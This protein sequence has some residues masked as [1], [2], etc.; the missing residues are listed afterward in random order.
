MATRFNNESTGACTGEV[1]ESRAE[2]GADRGVNRKRRVRM[3]I[4]ATLVVAITGPSTGCTM[5]SGMHRALTR[6]DGLDEFMVNYRNNAW[7]ARAWLCTK[8]EYHGHRYL[9][10]LEAGFRQ[11]Y[12]DV[13]A[14]GN[15][16]TPAICPQS[17]WGWQYQS[18]DGQQRMNAWFEGYPLGVKAAEEDGIGHWRRVATAFNAPAPTRVKPDPKTAADTA[19]DAIPPVPLADP[20]VPGIAIEPVIPGIAIPDGAPVVPPV[21]LPSGESLP[22]PSNV[23]FS[24]PSPGQSP[25]TGPAT[26]GASVPRGS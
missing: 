13:A 23:P 7:S 19:I 3:T 14:G 9:S 12:A 8:H 21:G 17:Y 6:H 5:F 24:I 2:L 18:A 15:G 10:D 25:G 1:G 4:L 11:G 22:L 20:G 26:D 16:C